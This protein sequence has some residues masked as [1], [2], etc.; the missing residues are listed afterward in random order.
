MTVFLDL[1]GFSI[2]FPIFPALLD[3]YLRL[4]GSESLIGRFVDLLE[5]VSPEH[6]QLFFVTVLFGGILGSL[7][8]ILQFICA[9]IWGR[10]SDHYGRRAVLRLTV[11]GT[12][13]SY[14]LWVFSG[15]FALFLVSR[16][17]AGA[18]AGN[19]SV[20]NAAMADLT[21]SKARARG[22]ALV[23]VAFGLG[24]ILGPAIGGLASVWSPF[25]FVASEPGF[26]LNPFSFPALLA[27]LIALLNTYWVFRVFRETLP[28]ERRSPKVQFRQLVR[29]RSRN[30][31]VRQAV[32]T[33]FC[34][35]LAFSGM[36]FTLS[37][38]AV[39]RLAYGPGQIALIFLFVG[40]MLVL[41]Q[42][43]IVRRYG[44]RIG[45]LNCV[46][47]GFLA[48]VLGMVCL[49]FAWESGW[50]YT[51][52]ALLAVGIGLS[53]PSLNALV[54]RYAGDNEQGAELGAFR[55][56]GSLARAFGPLIAAG[57]FWSF[58]SNFAY[59][60]GAGVILAT[61][62]YALTLPKPETDLESK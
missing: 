24:F 47:S 33:Y 27:L 12:A 18:M 5:R 55:S 35:M 14:L 3:Y 6:N 19:I 44:E 7:Y 20:A 11:T 54:S 8:S 1:V 39:E 42:G 13:L 40:F 22:M 48:L 59:V 43:V 2:I 31:R 16:V 60:G 23:G 26:G 25:T 49:S 30:P 10:L 29:L 61:L 62:L 51:G 37:F 45:E 34:L 15:S 21:E 28:D 57:V 41:T 50:F 46:F 4:E 58:G 38:L 17:L 52:L 9:P 36:E 32:R 53:N 56:A